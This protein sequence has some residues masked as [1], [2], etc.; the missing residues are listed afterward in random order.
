MPPYDTRLAVCLRL[1]Y[2][3]CLKT[4]WRSV[5][6]LMFKYVVIGLSHYGKWLRDELPEF[7]SRSLK[8]FSLCSHVHV[9]LWRTLFLCKLWFVNNM[10]LTLTPGTMFTPLLTKCM[11]LI[12]RPQRG[13]INPLP[14]N[15]VFRRILLLFSHT[16]FCCD[17]FSETRSR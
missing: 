11:S 16:H 10:P 12:K 7:G 15:F 3:V 2:A 8:G 9:R 4:V 14:S 5:G 17:S 6:A 1:F 13:I